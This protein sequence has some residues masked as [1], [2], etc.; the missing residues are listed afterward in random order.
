MK[1]NLGDKVM[2][3]PGSLNDELRYKV[4][5]GEI[6]RVSKFLIFRFYYILYNNNGIEKLECMNSDKLVK[7][8]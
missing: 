7:V 3:G 5:Y 2:F 1:F 8:K 6:V 4:Q